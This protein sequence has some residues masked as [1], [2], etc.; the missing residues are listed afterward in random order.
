MGGFWVD[1]F[2]VNVGACEWIFI[3]NQGLENGYLYFTK[4][5]AFWRKLRPNL[6]FWSLKNAIVLMI[7]FEGSIISLHFPFKLRSCEWAQYLNWL[8]W[9]S[10]DARRGM[11]RVKGVWRAAHPRTPISGESPP[12]AFHLN[13]DIGFTWFVSHPLIYLFP[14]S[15][16]YLP[17]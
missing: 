8:N 17:V 15:N 14:F 6:S 5:Q 12:P 13:V 1:N 4:F 3:K 11:K 7:D 9:E 10:C 2:A 16:L